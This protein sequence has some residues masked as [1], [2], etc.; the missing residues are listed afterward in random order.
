MSTLFGNPP[1]GNGDGNSGTG[2]DRK[3]LFPSRTPL[4]SSQPEKGIAAS[5]R[6]FSPDGDSKP[7]FPRR[8]SVPASGTQS[9]EQRSSLFSSRE[10][11]EP[12]F[13]RRETAGTGTATTRTPLFPP[14]ENKEPLFPRRETV[15]TG[16]GTA[17]TPLFPPRENREPLFPQK[18][19]VK[20]LFPRKDT[21]TPGGNGGTASRPLFPSRDTGGATKTSSFS[22]RQPC[23][24]SGR[25][26]QTYGLSSK[27]VF[28]APMSDGAAASGFSSLRQR[29][30]H[31]SDAEFIQLRD[32][33]YQQSGIFI[34]ENRKYLVENRLSS[35]LRELGLRS[36]GEYYNYL[37]YDSNRAA[38]LNKL[39]ESM[40]TN[41]TSFFRNG[42]QLEVF[43]DKVLVPLLAELRG[44]GQRKLRIWSAGCSSGEEPYTLA[45][46]LTEVLRQELHSWDIKITAND[47]S[48]AM[49]ASARRGLYNDY[50]IRTTPPDMLAKYF[51]KEGNLYRIAPSLQKLVSFGQINLSDK[52]QLAKV[53]RSHIVFCRNV[54]IYFDDEM[55]R[56]VIN[57]FYDNLLPGGYLLIGHS[58]SLHNISRAFKPEH[59]AGSIVYRKQV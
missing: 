47:L 10:N 3:P 27:P 56:N 46:I 33:L 11:R 20:P 13:P 29:D 49:L 21:S 41:E 35:R 16:A 30:I 1:S 58:E 23:S 36:F 40:T 17:R 45:I 37:R 19:G 2:R 57:A 32:F 31:V 38:E 25:S 6:S 34:A 48:L 44:K 43:R 26:A 18:E 42:P 39:F 24:E 15:G 5:G 53:E 55:K 7:L 52:A 54:I 9:Q 51:T 8:D 22:L 12:L 28:G 4:V 14:R 50:A 59:Y